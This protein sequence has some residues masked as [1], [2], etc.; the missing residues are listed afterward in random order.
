MLDFAP[1]ANLEWVDLSKN[2]ICKIEHLKQNPY[3]KYLFLDENQIEKIENIE[4]NKS[5]VVLSLR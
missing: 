4:N 2:Q 5:M 3:L 1:P